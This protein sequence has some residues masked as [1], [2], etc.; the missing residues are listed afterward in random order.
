MTGERPSTRVP[1]DEHK[2]QRVREFL[3]REF[4]S[5]QHRDVFAF[6]R[7]AQVFVIG[8]DHSLR[9]TLVI[10]KETFEDQDFALLLNP[11]LVTT[12]KL[13]GEARV[14]LTPQGA[15]TSTG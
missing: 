10:P 13:A 1:F 3:R 9:H 8:S 2:L 11:H 4:R 12:L 15:R 14:T 7:T 6:H 5:C